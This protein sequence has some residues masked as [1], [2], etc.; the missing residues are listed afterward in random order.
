MEGEVRVTEGEVRVMGRV[1]IRSEC[2][3]GDGW[4]VQ[5]CEYWR[6]SQGG[7]RGSDG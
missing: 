2:E 4:T 3:D 5:K 1:K 6:V 7:K